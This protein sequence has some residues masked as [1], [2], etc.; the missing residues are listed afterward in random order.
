MKD[1]E[2]F[3]PLEQQLM[4]ITDFLYDF[5]KIESKGLTIKDDEEVTDE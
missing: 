1:K 5:K 2:L 4:N 3:T